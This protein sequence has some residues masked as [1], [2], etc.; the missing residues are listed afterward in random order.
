MVQQLRARVRPWRSRLLALRPARKPLAKIGR[1][2]IRALYCV[3]TICLIGA[4]GI[5]VLGADELHQGAEGLYQAGLAPVC[6]R[7]P[8][9]HLCPDLGRDD[10]TW[11]RVA[12]DAWR[13][14]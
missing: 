5:L 6:R 8:T 9:F 4:S 14:R 2:M 13:N 7:D 10:R 12:I 1:P 3:V 11:L